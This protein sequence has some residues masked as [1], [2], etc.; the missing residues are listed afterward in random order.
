MKLLSS[1]T[2]PFGRKVMA[3]AIAR[4][5]EGQIE[6]VPT[7][8]HISPPSLTAANPLS[9]IPCLITVD[10]LALFD[11][12]VICEYLDTIGDAPKLYPRPESAARWHALKLHAIGDGILEAAVLRRGEQ[13][14]PMDTRRATQIERM[15]AAVTRALDH[16]EADPPGPG[17]DI[18]TLTIACALGYLDFRYAAE[19]WRTGRPR[20]AAWLEPIAQSPAYRRTIPRDPA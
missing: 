12:P 7:N 9:K 19:P 11:S 15:K 14:E 13:S 6:L 16:L 8:P 1:L 18:G 4:E 20:L 5:I 10:G 3:A 2:S 17:L